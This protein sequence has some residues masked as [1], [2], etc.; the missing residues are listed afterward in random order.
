MKF[1]SLLQSLD[2][3]GE[4]SRV[5]Q[6]HRQIGLQEWI[7]RTQGHRP[8][9]TL[10]SFT[11]LPTIPA[12]QPQAQPG[13]SDGRIHLNAGAVGGIGVLHSTARG[14]NL[15][16]DPKPV[17]IFRLLLEQGFDLLERRLRLPRGQQP[18]GFDHPLQRTR[19]RI[20]PDSGSNGWIVLLKF[21]DHQRRSLIDYPTIESMSIDG[22]GFPAP[23]PCL[24]PAAWTRTRSPRCCRRSE[25]CWS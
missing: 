9:E 10:A 6:H 18:I 21:H 20:F 16:Q 5:A 24:Y 2:R 19:R 23:M 17:R 12:Q 1:Q 11:R 4:P 7:Q 25:H 15:S 22:P 8:L 14:K 3:L 13:G